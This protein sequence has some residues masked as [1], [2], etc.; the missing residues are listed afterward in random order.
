MT[1]INSLGVNAL[2]IRGAGTDYH[3]LS[4]VYESLAEANADSG[5]SATAGVEHVALIKGLGLAFYN[6][7][8]TQ[9]EHTATE[10]ESNVDDLISL[11]GVAENTTNL[12]TFSGTTIG[13]NLSDPQEMQLKVWTCK[14][15]LAI[16]LLGESFPTLRTTVLGQLPFSLETRSYYLADLAA[17]FGVF[18]IESPMRWGFSNLA[19]G[20]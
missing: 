17:L 13:D 3:R 5:F 14:A 19:W 15:P 18:N 16:F 7:S 11:A 1:V 6:H 20:V 4:R 2:S 12:G 8:T 9:W 10:L